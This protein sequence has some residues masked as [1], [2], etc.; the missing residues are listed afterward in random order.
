MFKIKLKRCIA[1]LLIIVLTVGTYC[2]YSVL[3]TNNNQTEEEE[4]TTED[5]IPGF[6]K[7]V[8]N[9]ILNFYPSGQSTTSAHLFELEYNNGATEILCWANPSLAKSSDLSKFKSPGNTDETFQKECF[10]KIF[11]DTF[12]DLESVKI[13]SEQGA[14]ADGSFVALS[15]RMSMFLYVR[16]HPE[17]VKDE[18]DINN[19][20]LKNYGAALEAT[21]DKKHD[22]SLQD[23]LTR[24]G[25]IKEDE[26]SEE[27]II[28]SGK[29]N[30]K[31]Q[32]YSTRYL[33]VFS[34]ASATATGESLTWSPTVEDEVFIA[35]DYA[36]H[37]CLSEFIDFYDNTMVEIYDTVD[38]ETN[39]TCID[40]LTLAKIFA[41]AFDAYIPVVKDIYELKNPKADNMS[42]KDMVEKAGAEDNT[43][44]SVEMNSS[45]DYK[46]H[47]DTSTPIGEFYT[48]N[49]DMGIVAYDRDSVLNDIEVNTTMDEVL[50]DE[51]SEQSNEDMLTQENN[52]MLDNKFIVSQAQYA[53]NIIDACKAND[54]KKVVELLSD[55]HYSGILTLV[56]DSVNSVLYLTLMDYVNG[57][58]EPTGVSKFILDNNTILETLE[59]IAS[60]YDAYSVDLEHLKNTFESLEDDLNKLSKSKEYGISDDGKST[61]MA[62]V[63]INKNIIDGI[64]YSASFVP[65]RTNLYSTDVI[66]SF[67]GDEEFYEFYVKYGFMRKALYID[68]SSTSA[69]DYYTAGGTFTGS[70]KVCTLRDLLESEDSDVT[71]YIDSNFYNADE[72]I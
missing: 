40:N 39:Q 48:V 3:A 25:I 31:S 70:T 36:A 5:V 56:R 27:D 38:W 2:P 65:M 42:I 28:S 45:G 16:L 49:G 12:S 41:D 35:N 4:T 61:S 54:D 67:S 59:E 46:A 52:F 62:S 18:K 57:I 23:A 6:S 71:L 26:E 64:G 55:S 9:S 19:I 66:K 68:K 11:N 10:S 32:A 22:E 8:K 7:V 33:G 69:V 34:L 29:V 24:I 63:T 21:L 51:Y 15:M 50:S 53:K 43:S 47:T 17:K 37:I 58:V 30:S 44:S 14:S 60:N 13:A 20:T 72:A 1:S